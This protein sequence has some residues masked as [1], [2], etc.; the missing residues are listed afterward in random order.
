MSDIF[1][2]I[3]SGGEKTYKTVGFDGEG[4]TRC[5]GK[6]GTVKAVFFALPEITGVKRL[7]T[8]NHADTNTGN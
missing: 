8:T 4:E 7:T 6:N 5:H 1:V 3:R 2:H